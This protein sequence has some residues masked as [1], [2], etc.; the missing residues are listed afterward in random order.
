MEAAQTLQP[1]DPPSSFTSSCNRRQKFEQ[2]ESSR[3]LGAVDLDI[4]PVVRQQYSPQRRVPGGAM[5]LISAYE[6]ATRSHKGVRWIYECILFDRNFEV[7]QGS[8]MVASIV[9]CD[10]TGPLLA[11]VWGHA[12]NVLEVVVAEL[13]GN[14]SPIE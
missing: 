14:A 6:A 7:R 3:A 4:V 2:S 10:N 9:A 11:S 13:Y 12:V 5:E 1:L 8:R